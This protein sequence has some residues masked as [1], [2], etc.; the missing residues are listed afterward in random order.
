MRNRLFASMLATCL[1]ACGG[2]GDAADTGPDAVVDSGPRGVACGDVRCGRTRPCC[3][4]CDG[5][6]A[7][8]TTSV[9]PPRRCDPPRDASVPDASVG[10]ALSSECDDTDYCA[11]GVGAICA[12]PGECTARPTSCTDDCPMVCGCDGMD[13]CNAC[14]AAAAGVGLR[15]GRACSL[16]DLPC[17]GG[18]G[19]IDCG[20]GFYC[21]LPLTS[22]CGTAVGTMGTCIPTPTSCEPRFEPVCGCDGRGYMNAC[23]AF[24]AG[25]S[26]GSIGSSCSGGGGG[27]CRTDGCTGGE[28]CMLCSGEFTCT[29]PDMPC[30]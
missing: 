22:L 7:C 10:C 18:L 13:Y 25:T 3:V 9:C 26:I 5:E 28:L 8:S 15:S 29:A 20:D 12:I 16:A 14:Q 21:S 30:F 4:D 2:G 23:E 6:M 1:S 11:P 24:R 17:G 27:D 19:A